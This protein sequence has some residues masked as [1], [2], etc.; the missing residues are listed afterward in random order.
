MEMLVLDTLQ[1]EYNLNDNLYFIEDQSCS[2]SINQVKNNT[3]FKFYNPKIQENLLDPN[4]CYWIHFRLQSAADFSHFF[5]NWQLYLGESDFISV[6]QLDERGQIIKNIE[7]GNWY[8]LSLK[9][10]TLNHKIQRVKLSFDASEPIHFFIKYHKEDHQA[11][12]ID[13]RLKKYDFYQSIDYVYSSRQNWSFL[14]FVFTM[15]LLNF[16]FFISTQFNAFL[17]HGLFITGIFI[18]SFDLFG[19]TDNLIF[20]KDHPYLVQLVDVLAVGLADIAYFQFMRSYLSLKSLMPKWDKL[21]QQLL[22]IKLVFWPSVIIYYYISYNEPLTDKFILLF[23]VT[24]YVIA[25]VFLIS[26]LRK[27]EKNSLYLVA[28][29]GFLFLLIIINAISLF[30]STGISSTIIQLGIGGE[31]LCFSLGLAVRFKN[32]RKEEEEAIRLKELNRFKSQVL[33]NITH[34]FRTPLT[35][36]QG[37]SGI[38]KDSISKKTSKHDLSKAYDAI[39]RNSSSLLS[40]VNQMLDLAKL[41]SKGIHLD[42]RQHDLVHEID[43]TILS[44]QGAAIEKNIKLSFDSTVDKLLMD[45]DDEKFYTT[46]G[47]LISN[48]IKF[49]PSAGEVKL[50]LTQADPGRVMLR[51][52][53]S[54]IGI[55]ESN[56]PHIFDRFYQV[57]ADVKTNIGTGIGLSLVKELVELMGGEITVESEENKGSAFVIELPVRHTCDPE[58]DI[59][60]SS[61]IEEKDESSVLIENKPLLLVIE[62][63]VDVRNYLELLLA[64]AYSLK[65]AKDGLE[66]LNMAQQIIPDLIISDLMMP[67]LDGIRLCRQLK[68]DDKTNHIPIII[69]TA[70]VN[71]ENRLEGLETGAD[72]YLTKPFRKEE[73]FIRLRKLNESRLALQKKYSQFSLIEKPKKLK[74]E[75]SFVH[76][77]NSVIEENLTSEQFGVEDLAQQLH[78]SRMQLHRKLTAVADRSASNYIRSYRLYKAKPLFV[79]ADKSIGEIAW[80]VGFQ[81]AN[82]FSKSFHKEFGKTPSEYKE[83]LTN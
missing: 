1:D 16:L 38:F 30:N 73:L 60:E 59:G 39:D 6:Y 44:F 40:L 48:A 5:D 22:V 26:L 24:Q 20:I 83:S 36:I 4:S 51:V 46:I 82:Y 77:V 65:M 33:T 45:L 11:Y 69:L 79:D 37:V 47:N 15:L 21:F 25:A 13:V 80:A 10:E 78:M 14:G 71:F 41:E 66:G 43:E 31:I 8:P 81:D 72:A 64:E 56:L 35:I 68:A 27:K 52:S 32:L 75:N 29:S 55:S 53:D 62:D 63:N 58:E 54:G 17:Y 9:E 50:E 34:E 2:Y 49:T 74:K 42:L 76:K 12:K 19:I 23:L 28:G 61:L 7:T 57:D 70:K 67:K 18:F 3:G